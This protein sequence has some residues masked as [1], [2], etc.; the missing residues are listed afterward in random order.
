MTDSRREF[1]KKAALLAGG[2]SLF[3]ALPDSIQKALAIDPQP[4]STFQDAEHIVILMQENRSFDHC[5]GSLRGVRGFNDPRA[6]TLPNKNPV[7]LQTNA[8]GETYAPFRLNLKDTKA[9]WMS[10]LPHS[11]TNQ[12]DARNDGKYDKWLDSKQS[13]RKEYAKMPLTMGYY[14]RQ[15]IPFYYALADAF[16]VCDQNFCS[17]LTGTTPNRLYLWTGTIREKPDRNVKANVRNEDVD[18]GDPAHWKTFP[19]RLEENGISWRIY[20]NE[21]SLPVG[22]EGEEEGWLANFT[23]NPIEW[24]EQYNVGFSEAYQRYL[25]KKLPELPG[26]IQALTTKINALP[27]TSSELPK[28]KRELSRKEQELI[29]GREH[30][31]KYSREN[32]AKLSQREKNLHEKAFTTNK[33]DPHYHELTK[34]KYHDGSTEREVEIPKGDVL[35]QFRADVKNRTLPT[36]SWV[37]APENYSDHPGAAWYGAWYIS[38]MLDILTQNPDVWK[39]TVFILCYDENDGYFDHVPPFVAPHPDKPETGK[40][41]KGIDTSVEHVYMEHELQRKSPN[42][43]KEARA[44]AIGLGYRV[45]LVI[46]SPWS[47]GGKVSSEVFDH[48]S[49]LQ[50]LEVFLSKKTGKKIE[51][52]NISAWRRTV[53]GDLTSVFRPYKGEK[54][55]MPTFVEKNEFVESIHKAQFKELPSDFKVLTTDEIKKIKQAPYA[56]PLMPKQEKGLRSSLAI[57]YELYADGQ[58]D[59]D[60]KAFDIILQAKNDVF[61]TKSAGSPFTVYALNNFVSENENAERDVQVRNYA[62]AAGDRLSD[63]W[64]IREFENE[65]YQFRVNGPNGFFREFIGTANDP[66]VAVQ[67]DYQHTAPQARTLTGSVELNIT[68]LDPARAYTIEV[69]DNAYQTGTQTQTLAAAG[70]K[71]SRIS[72]IL[73]L[74]RSFGWYDFSVNVAGH[75]VFE[76]RYAGR[77]ETGKEGF[78][79]PVMGGELV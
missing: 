3:Q 63:R 56:S 53:C 35:H 48:T 25:T 74:S 31:V 14:N 75:P 10:S 79:D 45:P 78:S 23:D 26:E 55:P 22:F 39:K 58:F 41:S 62:V 47:R 33:N 50:F 32:Y 51:E 57:P 34:L 15:D 70:S 52:S 65:T 76:K 24:F 4:G 6:I 13:A 72:L 29:V 28:L 20:Q 66:R 40:V 21:L 71:G 1:L 49:I 30:Q 12:V 9:T 38:E 37:V 44:G 61:G 73:D 54:I 19:E 18:Y 59:P 46:A 60:Q 7:W 8:A 2:T 11:W 16:T 42:A 17:S 68:N 64:N 77:V 5:Y 69:K 36:V 43:Q 27:E 67:C